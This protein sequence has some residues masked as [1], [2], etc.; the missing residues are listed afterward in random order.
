MT[1]YRFLQGMCYQLRRAGNRV[2]LA[3]TLAA[4]R[5]H[6]DRPRKGFSCGKGSGTALHWY[7]R[8]RG[9]DYR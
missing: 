4:M 5:T 3:Q 7:T 6:P 9:V 2:A 1:S 8:Y